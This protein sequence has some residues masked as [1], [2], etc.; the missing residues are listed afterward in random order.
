MIID[1]GRGIA[2]NPAHVVSVRRD[3]HKTCLLI[4]DV[5]GKVHE[6]EKRVI[7][8]LTVPAPNG[9]DK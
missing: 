4:T 6:I 1:L 2:L 8:M 7:S 3:F 5:L 9:D